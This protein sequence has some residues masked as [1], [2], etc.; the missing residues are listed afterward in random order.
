[1]F[2]KG[3]DGFQHWNIILSFFRGQDLD[4]RLATLVLVLA[5]PDRPVVPTHRL[6]K[7]CTEWTVN[8]CIVGPPA[9][10]VFTFPYK[11]CVEQ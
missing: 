2:Q 5:I 7:V 11:D 10:A 8:S 9:M 1:M 6:I 3:E 4:Q